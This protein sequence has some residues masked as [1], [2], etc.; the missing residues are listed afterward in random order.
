MPK[1]I[2]EDEFGN[3]EIKFQQDESGNKMFVKV[4]Y[5]DITE[6]KIIFSGEIIRQNTA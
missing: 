3:Y 4:S 2:V 6:E 1:I 5:D